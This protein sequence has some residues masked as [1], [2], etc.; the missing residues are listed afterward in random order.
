MNFCI[1]AE[2]SPQVA[3]AKQRA[4]LA[5]ENLMARAGIKNM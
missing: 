3:A 2:Q 4:Q 1:V 5:E